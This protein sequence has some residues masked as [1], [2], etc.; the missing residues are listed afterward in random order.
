V[1]LPILLFDEL[2]GYYRSKT[3]IALWVGLPVLSFILKLITPDT[4]G[5]PMTLIVALVITSMGGMLSAVLLA[6]SISSE[7]KER[8]YDL[9]LIRPVKR[10]EIILS[11]FFAVFLCVTVA[12]TISVTVGLLWDGFSGDFS[13]DLLISSIREVFIQSIFMI[14][15]SCAVGIYIGLNV[16]SVLVAA[17]MSIYIGGQMSALPVLFAFI[18]TGVDPVILTAAISLV[19]VIV[20]LA[21]STYMFERKQF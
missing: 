15:V 11:K 6:T 21:A 10:V 18:T 8:V 13:S 1:T 9:Y 12:I 17:I 16:D 4:E 2:K 3:I 7:V 5:F 14:A 20:I 19:A